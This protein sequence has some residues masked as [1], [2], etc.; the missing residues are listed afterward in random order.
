MTAGTAAVVGTLDFSLLVHLIKRNRVGGMDLTQV[1]TS[2][3]AQP[4]QLLRLG[5]RRASPFLLS[6]EKSLIITLFSFALAI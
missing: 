3:K 2:M 1:K 5:N 6:S 4:S